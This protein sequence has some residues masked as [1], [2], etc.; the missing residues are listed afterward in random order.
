MRTHRKSWAGRF[1][2]VPF[3]RASNQIH[4]VIFIHP[5]FSYSPFCCKG[6]QPAPP[7]RLH[8]CKGKCVIILLHPT[9]F[10]LFNG[11]EN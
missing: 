6:L 5:T 4:I 7:I 8:K 2:R 9:D 3:S 11:W 1:G 10:Y